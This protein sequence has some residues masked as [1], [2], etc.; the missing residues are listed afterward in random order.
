MKFANGLKAGGVYALYAILAGTERP[1][2]D[3]PEAA[4]AGQARFLAGLDALHVAGK[5]HP[6]EPGKRDF[7][8]GHGATPLLL[9][10]GPPGTGKSYSTAFAVLAR[11]Q[12]AMAANRDFRVF[13]SCK[14]HAATDVL[15]DN[16]ADAQAALG[17]LWATHPHIMREH[18]DERLLHLPL[19]R[20]R[21]RGDVPAGVTPVPKDAAR[22]EGQPKAVERLQAQRWLVAAGTPGGIYGL[23]PSGGSR[24]P[25]SGTTSPIASC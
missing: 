9:V 14:T 11:I 1:D 3:W 6:F 24:R 22:R 4:V 7:I 17:R 15:L 5:M 20:L 2:P 13:L 10:Q 25:L 23:S 19:Y 21:P 18:F 12:G 8:G 16:V